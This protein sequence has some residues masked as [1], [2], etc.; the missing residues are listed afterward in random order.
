MESMAT[1]LW[2][3]R[4]FRLKGIGCS[5]AW[6]GMDSTRITYLRHA[7]H[8]LVLLWPWT[9]ISG[10]IWSAGRINRRWQMWHRKWCHL[11]VWAA[12]S[13]DI[14]SHVAPQLSI[15]WVV[16]LPL[17]RL[18]SAQYSASYSHPVRLVAPLS[19]LCSICPVF[20]V[21]L[22]IFQRVSR[23]WLKVLPYSLR[24]HWI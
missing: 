5:F 10:G 9:Q 21:S 13:K 11:L 17:L 1:C 12:F 15:T 6:G 16:F 7:T 19:L 23:F 18:P 24:L 14:G 3:C 4:V 20:Q 22:P 8:K 2:Q